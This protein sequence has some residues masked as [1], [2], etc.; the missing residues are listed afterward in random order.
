LLVAAAAKRSNY[1]K[2]SQTR[3]QWQQSPHLGTPYRLAA[4]VTS[5]NSR[6]SHPEV[7][8]PYLAPYQGTQV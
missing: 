5:T 7:N 8:A 3:T 6:R 4:V 2:L 1:G